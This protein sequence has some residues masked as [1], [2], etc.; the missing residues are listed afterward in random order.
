MIRHGDG[1]RGSRDRDILACRD[2]TKTRNK[3]RTQTTPGEVSCHINISYP[4]SST[5]GPDPPTQPLQNNMNEHTGCDNISNR[6]P[7]PTSYPSPP[8]PARQPPRLHPAPM[9]GRTT[10]IGIQQEEAQ[11]AR[12]TESYCLGWHLRHRVIPTG[13][14]CRHHRMLRQCHKVV[15]ARKP[16]SCGKPF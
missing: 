16:S 5:P 7:L 12:T 3:N 4:G 11:P 14:V 10:E 9:A 15:K 2:S 13:E 6:T 1:H 8:P